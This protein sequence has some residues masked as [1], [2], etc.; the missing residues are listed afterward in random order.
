MDFN[1]LR[2]L[3]KLKQDQLNQIDT[4]SIQPIPTPVPPPDES[5]LTP[6][7]KQRLEVYKRM[8]LK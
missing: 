2:Q 8:G 4:Q 6:E 1:R 5:N 3:L 7:E